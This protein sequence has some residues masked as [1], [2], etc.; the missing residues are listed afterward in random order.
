MKY[1][2]TTVLKREGMDSLAADIIPFSDASVKEEFSKI[3]MW[4]ADM[5]FAT[6]PSV[7]RAI[8]KRLEHP[9]FGYFKL[10]DAYFDAIIGWQKQRFG[11]ENLT[12]EDIGYENGVLGG[13]T[14]ALDSFCSKGDS[15]LL[16]APAYIGFTQTLKNNGYN[17]VFSDLYQDEHGVWRMDYEDMKKKIIDNRIHAAVF[18]SP[19]NPSGRVFERCEIERA[20]EVYRETDCIVVADEIWADITLF[21]N[22]HIPAQSVSEDAKNRTIAVYAPSKTFNLAGLVGSYHIIYNRYLRDRFLKQSSLTHY[23]MHN[24]LSVHALI[25]AYSA[26]GAEWVDELRKV[27]S[28]NAAYAYQYILDNFKGISLFRPQGTYMLFLNCEGWC[29]EH[30]ISLDDLI[31]AG[32]SVGVIWQDGR[33]FHKEGTIR[34]NLALPMSLLQEALERLKN[35]VFCTKTR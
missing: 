32:I 3:P 10:P 6:A 2:F 29:R 20:M 30:E 25:G 24:V 19:H 17:I 8:S 21:G 12:K 14:S 34:M 5:S 16:H 28:D 1:D 33:P 13:V 23:N 11:V 31:R 35:Y 22:R 9:V 18:C 7:T 27:L 26:E 4:V 15:V